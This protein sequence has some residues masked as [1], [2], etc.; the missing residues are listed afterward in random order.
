MGRESLVLFRP[1]F[2]RLS[3]VG[4][5]LYIACHRDFFASNAGPCDGLSAEI[6]KRPVP[7]WRSKGVAYLQVAP[8][9]F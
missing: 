9:A 3:A 1:A 2:F 5:S 4:R 8:E 7:M 6:K